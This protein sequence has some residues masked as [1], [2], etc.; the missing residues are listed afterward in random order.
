MTVG[1]PREHWQLGVYAALLWLRISIPSRI[2]VLHG[3][4]R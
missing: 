2:T 3:T 4:A 1:R